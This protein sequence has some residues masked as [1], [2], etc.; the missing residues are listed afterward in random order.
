MKAAGNEL[1]SLIHFSN[2]CKDYAINYPM[3]ALIGLHLNIVFLRE[4]YRGFRVIA[5]TLL[6]INK[7]TLIYGSFPL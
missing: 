5:V 7:K 1:R 6:P 2:V 3:M 4:D